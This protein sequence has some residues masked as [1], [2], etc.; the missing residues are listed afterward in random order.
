M[1]KQTVHLLDTMY[2]EPSVTQARSVELRSI[3]GAFKEW[4]GEPRL[5]MCFSLWPRP[6][7]CL[8]VAITVCANIIN[9]IWF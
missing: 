9:D 4:A 1:G 7:S 2:L 8:F 6:Y 5:D 3:D